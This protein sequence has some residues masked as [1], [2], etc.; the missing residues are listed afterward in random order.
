MR[1]ST[2]LSAAPLIGIVCKV[3]CSPSHIHTSFVGLVD[4]LLLVI[5]V[6][7]LC[8]MEGQN[9]LI[10]CRIDRIGKK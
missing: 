10:T 1:D 5:Q 7:V 6:I 3:Q 4:Y 9:T 8:V 2:M